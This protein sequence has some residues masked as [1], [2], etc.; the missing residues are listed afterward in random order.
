[1]LLSHV[2]RS[3]YVFSDNISLNPKQPLIRKSS[4]IVHLPMPKS[5]KTQANIAE[6]ITSSDLNSTLYYVGIGASAGGL[7]AL[8]PFVANLPEAANMTYII[9]QHMSP[10]HRSLMV[11]LLQRETNLKVEPAKS[12][13]L[14]LA[15]TIY[16]APANTDVTIS[17]GFL[18]LS[19][20]SNTVG[21]KPSVDRF[22]MSLAEDK[23]D[24]C[25]AIVLS[26]T[27]SDG[28]HGIKAIKA[29]GGITIAQ[30]P[31]S[32]KYDSMPNAAIR[33]GGADL[34]LPPS[35]I[36]VQLNTLINSPRTAL[37][38][39]LDVVPPSTMLGII[40]QIAN[41]TGM[42]FST[43]KEA[44]LSRQISRRMMAKQIPTI[45]EY[46]KYLNRHEQELRELA[47]N[48]LICVTSFFR[49]PDAFQALGETLKTLLGKKQPGDEIRIWMPGCA[50]GEE[51]YSVAIL[52]IENLG[53]RLSQHRIQ[54][55]ATDIN[56][57]AVHTARVGVYP[58][59][60]LAD[61]NDELIKKYF[62]LQNGLYQVDRRLK[63]M[64]LFARQDISQDPP[65][66]RLDLISCR[67][68][69]I[70]FKPELQ[71]K[72]MRI[73]H[74]SLYDNGVLFLGKSETVGKC[75]S[76]FSEIDRKNKIYLKRSIA[77]PV[78]GAFGRNRYNLSAAE[79]QPET[80]PVIP[81]MNLHT[82][83]IEQ[84][85]NLYSPPSVLVTLDGE[86]VEV[87]GDCS[88]FLSIRKGKANFNIYNLISPTIRAELRAFVH[89]VSKNK[90]SAYS[91]PFKL[92][93]AG[94]EGVYRV[95]T[96]YA[97][98][99]NKAESDLLLV[100]FETVAVYES[101]PEHLLSPNLHATA[102]VIELEQELVLNRENLQTVI[103]EL[104]TTNEELQALNEEAQAANEEL[105]ASNEELET[106]N[107]ELQ[108]SNEELI[109][110]ND[111]LNSRT[112]EL[113]K[114]NND[115]SNVLNSLYK[116]ILLIDTHLMVTRFN[117]IA[118]NFF[119][120]PV[121]NLASLTTIHSRYEMPELLKHVQQVIK[122]GQ[123]CEYEF[124]G[125]AQQY[126][127]MRLTPY[128]D[129][130]SQVSV[131]TGVVITI[132]DISEKKEADDKLKLWASVFKY[133]AEGSI[134][135]DANNLIIAVNPAFSK[136]TGYAPEDVIGKNPRILSSGQQPKD[137]YQRMWDDLL[138]NGTWQGELHNRRKNGE[139]Y[140]E[141]LSIN[142]LKE[143]DG[144]V[145]R[146][147]G[148]FSDIT[149]SKNALQIIEHQANYDG[150][151][152]LPNRNLIQERVRQLI[153]HARHDQKH[154]AVMFMDLDDFKAVNDSLGHLAGDELIFITASRISAVLRD[155]DTVGRLG[156]DEFIVLVDDD[157]SPS[158]IVSVALK[159]LEAIRQPT[160]IAGHTVQTSA[161][162][163]ITVFPIDG[164]SD[165]I[166]MKNA[167]SAMYEAKHKGRNTYCFFTPKMQEEADKRQWVISE[168][169]HSLI[170]HHMRIHYQPIIDVT[171]RQVAGAEALIR[172]QHPE[173]GLIYPDQFIPIAEHNGVISKMSEWL[174]GQCL[175]DAQ[176]LQDKF[177]KDFHI[178]LNISMAEFL[179]QDHMEWLISTLKSHPLAQAGLITL[180]LTESIKLI[181][182][183]DYKILLD[184]LKACGCNIAL[185]DFGTGQ[186]SLSYLKQVPVDII[187][188][189]KSFVRDIAT[190]PND[191][192]MVLAILQMAKAFNL[193]TV[194]EGVEDANQLN[195]LINNGCHYVQGYLLGKPMPYEAL[196][197]YIDTFDEKRPVFFN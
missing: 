79:T 188:I 96:H 4:Q 190:D 114:S 60:A 19:K 162:I 120:I 183:Q 197:A 104:E 193:S 72:V 48:F 110:V 76:L 17:E 176:N 68:L 116:A 151:T 81:D 9:A 124:K 112:L 30:A 52:L 163:G 55:F 29:A 150:L 97:G 31:Q 37:L 103:E 42:D 49:D 59:A 38:D 53:T 173:K 101:K 3:H 10:D 126:F 99:Q 195:F 169:T 25:I 56:M 196:L 24:K 88:G 69:L 41:H 175:Q 115:L 170:N 136:I 106:T 50:T 63:D 32:A 181:D 35:E 33:T 130:N 156:G 14:P 91:S 177:A 187:K 149:E 44:T 73:F 192:A 27:G 83:T 161:S 142:L 77:T 75:G 194:A 121:D 71:E 46:G 67:N 122:F 178:A 107:E 34:V 62:S 86:I 43:Y 160:Q 51:V 191:A 186:S 167:D 85:L 18:R 128:H 70:Y 168:L 134:I 100:S 74:Y 65:F 64:I 137:F 172:W 155:T 157:I 152:G 22:F 138:T 23:E 40:R 5:S 139:L 158:G 154:F 58:E 164:D 184:R 117:Q 171:T 146:H 26:G 12:D 95:A 108:A 182:K 82:S 84:L 78:I 125:D 143:E 2:I 174:I 118:L 90:S 141:F 87:F 7:E 6:L 92:N 20:P 80:K 1:M 140:T 180:E 57:E 189:D 135:T 166:L 61:L 185:D 15:N 21:P 45:K 66:V 144:K 98:D 36:A 129:Q 123:I 127:L 131:V 11:E 148:V 111:E 132:F 133:A 89:R 109:T 28:A 16:V 13:I 147:I 47:S 113:T 8:R 105:Q 93:I 39:D 153:V 145:T 119:D 179:S 102:R 54:I 165:H 159:I 94:K